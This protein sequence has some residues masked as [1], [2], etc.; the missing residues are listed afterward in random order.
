MKKK[1]NLILHPVLTP[2]N[3][4]ENIVN[5]HHDDLRAQEA[6]ACERTRVERE[7]R[8]RRRRERFLT[9]W[10]LL[11]FLAAMAASMYAGYTIGAG[12]IL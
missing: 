8:F 6:R 9:G 5:R 1:M 3:V 4:F 12:I 11:A 7:T 2:E 10:L